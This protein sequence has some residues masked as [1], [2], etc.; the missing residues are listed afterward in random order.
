MWC[1]IVS[2]IYKFVLYS[3][4]N[5]KIEDTEIKNT[6]IKFTA[7]VRGQKGAVQLGKINSV[8]LTPIINKKVKVMVEPLKEE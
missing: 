4:M 6:K 5:T 8:K 2:F 1:V 7:I 3:N